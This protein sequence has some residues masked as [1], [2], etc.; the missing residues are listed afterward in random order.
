MNCYL[1]A[2]WSRR[3]EIQ[4]VAFDLRAGG[5]GVTANWLEDG[6]HPSVTTEKSLREDAIRDVADIKECDAFVRFTDDI[7]GQFV[8]SHIASGARMFEMGLAWS[9]GKPIYVVGG[10]QQIFD[11]LPNIIH[12]RD[13]EHL[14]RE[15]SPV[16]VN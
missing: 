3:E 7:S 6:N 15:L 12:V 5:I 14:K 16:E 11:R 13:V 8:P 1:A 9:L 10:K 2:A 4:E